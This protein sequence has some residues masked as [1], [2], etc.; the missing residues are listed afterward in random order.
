MKN[1][2]SVISRSPQNGNSAAIK[3]PVVMAPAV[4]VHFA[5]DV[6]NELRELGQTRK[7][8]IIDA[9]SPKERK[10]AARGNRLP[11]TGHRRPDKSGSNPQTSE[12]L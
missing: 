1:Q 9:P 10:K 8:G 11:N 4:G 12:S 7:P 6:R 3:E 5:F 2:T